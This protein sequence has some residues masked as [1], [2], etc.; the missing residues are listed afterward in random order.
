MQSEGSEIE[1]GKVV[2]VNGGGVS[3][4]TPQ[5]ALMKSLLR[6]WRNYLWNGLLIGDV[7]AWCSMQT[8]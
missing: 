1:R 6:R 2:G 3:N 4:K 8:N 5:A 7:A